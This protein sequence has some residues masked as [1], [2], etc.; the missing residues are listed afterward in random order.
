MRCIRGVFFAL[1]IIISNNS[2][3]PEY[4]Q[5]DFINVCCYG[6]RIKIFKKVWKQ[7]L[8]LRKFQNI[9][10]EHMEHTSANFISVISL[11]LALVP[12]VLYA[13]SLE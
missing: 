11:S 8:I 12:L 7:S 2:L 10:V 9:V 3:S 6:I 5:V 1:K 13:R 4:F